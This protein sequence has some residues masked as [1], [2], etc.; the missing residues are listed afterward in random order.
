MKNETQ[1][2]FVLHPPAFCAAGAARQRASFEHNPFAEISDRVVT[3][4]PH[5]ALSPSDGERNS[6]F[7]S[8]RKSRDLL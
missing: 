2:E 1:N 7:T 3:E 5:P 8:I 4:T 6:A